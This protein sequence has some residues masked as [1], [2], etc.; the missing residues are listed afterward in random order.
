MADRN[1]LY[2]QL[3]FLPVSTIYAVRVNPDQWQRLFDRECDDNFKGQ[4]LESALC[5]IPGIVEACYDDEPVIRFTLSA[6]GR[7]LSG[8]HDT[9]EI[10]ERIRETILMH[11]EKE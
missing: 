8:N 6:T 4:T 7:D 5:E 3:P 2:K 10:R 11:L 1:P 9:P